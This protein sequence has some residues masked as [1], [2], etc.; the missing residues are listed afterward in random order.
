MVAVDWVMPVEPTVEE[1][2][3][4][5]ELVVLIELEV[6]RAED[7]VVD[8]LVVAD[9]PEAAVGNWVVAVTVD[10]VMVVGNWVVAVLVDMVVAVGDW[11]VAVPPEVVVV[12]GVWVMV[13]AVP[14]E[15]V[16]VVGDW[17]VVMPPEMVS[18]DD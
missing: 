10:V 18:G 2:E 14:V 7:A 6:L 17:V 16:L 9:P 13:V 11:V 8:S 12:V 3:V 15:V 1:A 5:P 4:V